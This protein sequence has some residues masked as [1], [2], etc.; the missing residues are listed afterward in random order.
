MPTFKHGAVYHMRSHTWKLCKVYTALVEQGLSYFLIDINYNILSSG[1]RPFHNAVPRYLWEHQE[2]LKT[3][4]TLCVL[5]AP[6]NWT[7]EN[8]HCNLRHISISRCTES[9][10]LAQIA[11]FLYISR[12]LNH[13]RSQFLKGTLLVK[14]NLLWIYWWPTLTLQEL[15]VKTDLESFLYWS[16][17]TFCKIPSHLPS[18]PELLA[19]TFCLITLMYLI[20][21]VT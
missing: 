8:W 3:H 19:A 16:G 21:S 18:A 14:N 2:T 10:A 20:P 6:L 5:F 1:F 12:V 11:H 13:N 9:K 7:V 17:N 4:L 15:V